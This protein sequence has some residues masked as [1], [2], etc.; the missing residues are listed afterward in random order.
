MDYVSSS[1]KL[2]LRG[3]N[4]TMPG[5]RL[6]P[7]WA[8]SLRNVRCYRVGEWRQRP[9]FT[10][11]ADVDGGVAEA[12]LYGKRI[13]NSN[14][15]TFRR[16]VGT[17][18]GKVYV[19][20]AAH[21]AFS[22]ADS[23]YSAEPYSSVISRPDRSPLPYLFLANSARLGKFST[24]GTRTNWGLSAPIVPLTAELARNVY[25]VIDDCDSA[26]GF[27]GTGGVASLQSRVMAVAI[28]QILY[29]SGTTGWACVA[30]ASMDE[31]WQE[32]MFVT[33]SAAAESVIIESI[34]P[35]IAST[36]IA[37]ILY[38]SGTSGPCTIQLSTHH[39]S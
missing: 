21:T 25:K 1:N 32:G 7:E 30:P 3:M 18:G 23:G 13:N 2:L 37:S 17:T 11:I 9:G 20:D 24:N 27:T 4:I 26:T 34:Y 5:D 15:G 39:R 22:L 6:G 29:D 35:A 10:Q 8:Q 14:A 12:I 28:S 36:T 33:T 31:S 16:L 38:D 19:D